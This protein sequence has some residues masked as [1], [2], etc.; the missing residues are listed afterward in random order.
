MNSGKILFRQYA[1]LISIVVLFAFAWIFVDGNVAFQEVLSLMFYIVLIL[2]SVPILRLIY[3]NKD[4]VVTKLQQYL[5]A[6][7]LGL[8]FYAMN[9]SHLAIVLIGEAPF[10]S[11]VGYF[12]ISFLDLA[13]LPLIFFMIIRF[14]FGYNLQIRRY[15]LDRRALLCYFVCA[16]LAVAETGVVSFIG[17]SYYSQ[18]FSWQWLYNSIEFAK[19]IPTVVVFALFIFQ[20]YW[21][22]KRGGGFT[23]YESGRRPTLNLLNVI[24]CLI[25][26]FLV[27]LFLEIS[28]IPYLFYS[29]Y[30]YYS[31]V[32]VY[33]LQFIVLVGSFFYP[34]FLLAINRPFVLANRSI[35]TALY[36]ATSGAVIVLVVFSILQYV[37]GFGGQDLQIPTLFYFAIKNTALFV[38][39]FIQVFK[40]YHIFGPDKKFLPFI[41]SI[42]LVV[43]GSFI[44]IVIYQ[45]MQGNLTPIHQGFQMFYV[46]DVLVGRY[47]IQDWLN[48]LMFNIVLAASLAL[49]SLASYGWS[50]KNEISIGLT[51]SREIG[52]SIES[53][54]ESSCND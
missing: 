24:G 11:M 27:L 18:E 51:E 36:L 25:V 9:F 7:I 40:I 20:E 34:S 33:L 15:L 23:F 8:L 35:K 6:A 44:C 48:A 47:F 26:V 1:A 45:E 21:I 22:F 53:K 43:F 4:V 29:F 28:E 3:G 30:H 52:L 31:I 41:A 16:I 42:I 37:F 50:K 39:F 38:V 19:I 54:G 5:A 12:F 2:S 46:L 17:S 49:L 14:S 10:R 32:Y 13:E